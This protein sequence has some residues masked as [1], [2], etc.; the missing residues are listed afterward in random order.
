MPFRNRLSRALLWRLSDGFDTLARA[1]G[2]TRNATVKRLART[3]GAACCVTRPVGFLRREL[4][5]ASSL[6]TYSLVGRSGVAFIRHPLLDMW[7]LEEIFR[8][9]AYRMPP[10]VRSALKRE[11]G[12]ALRIVD[13][14]GHV[15]LFGLFALDELP[16]S[17]LISYEPDPRNAAVLERTAERNSTLASRWSIRRAAAATEEGDLAFTSAHH[18][19]RIGDAAPEVAAELAEVTAVFPF[20]AGGRLAD[21][22]VEMVPAMDAFEDLGSADLI[23]VDIEGGEWAILG[24][25]RFAD[26]GVDALVVEYHR[27]GCPGDDPEQTVRSLLAEAGLTCGPATRGRHGDGVLWAWRESPGR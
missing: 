8:L 13:L 18:F 2:S 14:G 7:V 10:Q 21:A 26:L 22:T 9:G 6:A 16:G 24:D 17:T 4:S 3:L 20:L 15:G 12:V 5:R 19:S 25:P 11:L 27:S 23:K 1:L